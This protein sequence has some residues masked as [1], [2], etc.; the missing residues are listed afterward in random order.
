[1]NEKTEE[2]RDIFTSVTDGEETVTE[3]QEDTRGSLEK[4]E[5]TVEERLENVIAQMHERYGFETPL[6][7]A[8]LQTVARR[9]Y[10]RDGDDEIAADLEVE[11][12]DVFEARCALHLVDEGDA[13]EI[14][15]VAI[16]ERDEA[17]ATLAEE[18]DVDP[19]TIRR[20]RLVAAAKAES[21][22]ANDRYR[23]EFDSL[24]ADSELASRM[25]SDVREDGLEDATEGMETDVSF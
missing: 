3:S 16:R 1:M 14:D 15:L 11:P 4:D 7:E 6:S 5:R 8:E 12:Q 19:K 10:E 9:Y 24:L 2:L 18:Y 23:D 13:D 25:A 21:R 20:Y 22:A 17:D